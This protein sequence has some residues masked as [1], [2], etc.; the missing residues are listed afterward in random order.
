MLQSQMHHEDAETNIA[1]LMTPENVTSSVRKDEAGEWTACGHACQTLQVV[2]F[3]AA[4]CC[5][6]TR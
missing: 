4:R 6:Q 5:L 3:A 1:T 2:L